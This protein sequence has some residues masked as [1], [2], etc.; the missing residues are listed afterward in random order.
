MNHTDTRPLP[1][2]A[3]VICEFNPFHNGHARLLRAMRDAV[4]TDGVVI[5]AM[6]GR[7]VQRG[8]PAV[9]DPYVRAAAALAGGADLVV[10]LPFPW[11]CGAAPDFA[12]GGVSVLSGLGVGR[13]A[14]GSECGGEALLQ[15]CARLVSDPDF[16]AAVQSAVTGGAGAAEA[17]TQVLR[18]RVSAP[19]PEGFPQP[20]DRLAVHY[21][22]AAA[23]TDMRPLI[24]R[25]DGQD[26]DDTLLTD[27]AAPSATALRV[28]LREAA[29]DPDTLSAMLAGTMPDES[30]AVLLRAVR[31]GEAPCGFDALLPY[32]HGLFRMSDPDALSR[33]AGLSGGLAPRMVKAARETG[34]GQAFR[35]ALHTRLY[36]D[37][38]LR[39][40]MLY[41]AA[42]VTEADVQSLPQ[43]T[44]LLGANA[45]GCAYLRAL[46]KA[47][48]A[49]VDG[50][51][52]VVTK[53]ADV[54]ACRQS[55]LARAAD[56]LFTL[57]LPTP[58][59]AG[60]LMRKGPV[61]TG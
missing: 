25:R 57:C 54:P 60:A 56:A 58:A 27:A 1:P 3:G 49:G 16:T 40:E 18:S 24:I 22:A 8:E 19:L 52:P 46:R 31:A 13:L 61:I 39:R 34:N 28:L 12:R 20:N 53:P 45:R 23:G 41:A 7:F 5:C 43:Y 30:L 35:E 14:F 4:G 15:D 42:G 2:S 6:S 17:W 10:E 26:Y 48:K 38:R 51:L 33:I 44:T 9:C 21:L 11:S 55:A 29:C 37:A 47:G 59:P 32:L 50:L 36:T